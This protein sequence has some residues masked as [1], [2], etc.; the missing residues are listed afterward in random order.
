MVLPAVEFIRRFLQH[1]LPKQFVR[2]RHYGFLASRYRQ[3]KLGR[4]RELLSNC[5]ESAAPTSNREAVLR[6]MLGH[7]PNQCPFC[8]VGGWRPYQTIEPHPSRRRWLVVVQ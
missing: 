3:Q 7:D 4:C 5:E 2:V 6:Q 8:G 1:V